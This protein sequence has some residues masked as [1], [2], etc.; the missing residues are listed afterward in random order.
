MYFHHQNVKRI[1]FCLDRWV[2]MTLKL[3]PIKSKVNWPL[4]ISYFSLKTLS[5]WQFSMAVGGCYNT[6]RNA[7][8]TGLETS[9]D[10]VLLL[11]QAFHVGIHFVKFYSY[12]AIQILNTVQ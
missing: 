10:H 3:H 7:L 2:L 9:S 6:L 11:G 4:K 12:V 1:T 5:F 8:W